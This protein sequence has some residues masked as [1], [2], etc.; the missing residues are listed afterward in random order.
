MAE[1]WL[2]ILLILAIDF[3]LIG[4][5]SAIIFV[6]CTGRSGGRIDG[7]CA[8]SPTPWRVASSRRPKL[9]PGEPSNQRA[10][11]ISPCESRR[12]AT[13]RPLVVA[14]LCYRRGSLWAW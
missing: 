9:P 6:A 10:G 13:P 7:R 2:G 11:P 12:E 14:L 1:M 8:A 4:L 3:V 5:V